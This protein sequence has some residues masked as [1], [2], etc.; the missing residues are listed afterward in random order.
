MSHLMTK[1]QQQNDLTPGEGTDQPG[2][3]LSLIRVCCL[4]EESLDP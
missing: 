2:H 4:H 1:K 3:L